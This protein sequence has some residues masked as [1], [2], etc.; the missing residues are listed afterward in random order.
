M[1]SIV[2]LILMCFMSISCSLS[3]NVK[4]KREKTITIDSLYCV[5]HNLPVTAFKITFDSIKFKYLYTDDD[6]TYLILQNK[7]E[8][9]VVEEEIAFGSASITNA[10]KNQFQDFM[11]FLKNKY[12]NHV[13]ELSLVYSEGDY[14]NTELRFVR[15]LNVLDS[16]EYVGKYSSVMTLKTSSSN[17]DLH[18]VLV[19]LAKKGESEIS[20]KDFKFNTELGKTLNSFM[21]VE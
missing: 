15:D 5:N 13:E 8:S 16:E 7:N 20:Y 6:L 9:G 11:K 21:Y 2:F 12:K 10:D 1:K 19:G 17:N 14:P 3:I 4:D 18:C